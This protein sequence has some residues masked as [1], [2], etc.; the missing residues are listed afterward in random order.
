[1]VNSCCHFPV[2][3]DPQLIPE[4]KT[5]HGA[6]VFFKNQNTYWHT[7]ALVYLSSIFNALSFKY[8]PVACFLIFFIGLAALALTRPIK[9]T[10]DFKRY[11]SFT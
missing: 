1:M 6:T 8:P 10:L 4:K 2:V 3:G 11:I 7:N 5:N 9:I